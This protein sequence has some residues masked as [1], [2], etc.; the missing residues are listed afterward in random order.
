MNSRIR[1]LENAGHLADAVAHVVALDNDADPFA[2][3]EAIAQADRIELH[4]PNFTDGRAFSQAYLIRRRLGFNGD[5][6]SGAGC[7][8][9]V[10]LVFVSVY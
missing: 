5:L 4:F 7:S 6:R 2:Y 8:F 3:S 1:I 9:L 10:E